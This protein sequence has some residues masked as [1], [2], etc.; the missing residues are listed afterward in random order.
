MGTMFLFFS[1]GIIISQRLEIMKL[2]LIKYTALIIFLFYLSCYFIPI[3]TSKVFTEFAMLASLVC[4]Y[5]LLKFLYRKKLLSHF[6]HIYLN[7]VLEFTY[8][9]LLFFTE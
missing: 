2:K 6:L 7:G 4:M 5:N 8:I 3:N 9:T 1:V